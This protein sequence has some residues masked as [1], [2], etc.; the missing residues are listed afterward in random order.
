MVLKKQNYH[1]RGESTA[2]LDMDAT[3]VATSKADA[4]FCLHPVGVKLHGL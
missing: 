1:Q 2:I 3:L 4:L